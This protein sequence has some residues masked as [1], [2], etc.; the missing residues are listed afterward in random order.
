MK[1]MMIRSATTCLIASASIS[2]AEDD[3]APTATTA[4]HANG[5]V[6]IRDGVIHFLPD[7]DKDGVITHCQI[8][9]EKLWVEAVRRGEKI[10]ILPAWPKDRDVSF[11]L[12]APMQT[13][14]ECVVHGVI[15]KLVV[16]S[17][18]RR[19]NIQ[20]RRT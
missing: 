1:P 8:E 4:T 9:G 20:T 3:S 12:H 14:V 18:A 17:P 6:V 5:S 13:T 16:T 2:A 10:R 11:K 7:G 19:K 15:V